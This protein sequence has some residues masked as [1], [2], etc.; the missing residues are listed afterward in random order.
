VAGFVLVALD[1]R[2]KAGNEGERAG[3]GT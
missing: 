3:L 1:Y 2:H